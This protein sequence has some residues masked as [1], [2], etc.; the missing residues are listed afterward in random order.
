MVIE[1]GGATNFKLGSLFMH[2]VQTCLHEDHEYFQTG[3]YSSRSNA[4]IPHG[5]FDLLLENSW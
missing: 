1:D 2:H 3:R 5:R 4:F